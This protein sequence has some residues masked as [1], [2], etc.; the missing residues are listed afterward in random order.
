MDAEMKMN[1]MK[2][3]SMDDLNKVNG[4]TAEDLER[5]VYEMFGKYGVSDMDTLMDVISDADY[6]SLVDE[7]NKKPL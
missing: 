5:A 3:L 2:K 1:G 6:I 4:G 7:L